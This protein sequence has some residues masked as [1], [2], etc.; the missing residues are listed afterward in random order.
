MSLAYWDRDKMADILQ[1]VFWNAN[2][3]EWKLLHFHSSF[4]KFIQWDAI[5]NE[6]VLDQIMAWHRTGDKPLSEPMM[7]KIT[8]AYIRHSASMS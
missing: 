3:S 4:T 1:T 5:D 7:E 8:A 2:S 6:P